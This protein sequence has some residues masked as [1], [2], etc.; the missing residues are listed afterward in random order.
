VLVEGGTPAP[1][2]GARRVLRRPAL[3]RALAGAGALVD[4]V[5]GLDWEALAGDQAPPGWL[6]ELEARRADGEFLRAP[7]MTRLARLAGVS[8]EHLSRSYARAYGTSLAA[9]LRAR[10]LRAGYDELTRS[11]RPLAEVAD[12]CGFADQSHLTRA[13]AEWIGLTPGALRRRGITPIQDEDP[14]GDV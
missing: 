1:R 10:R 6:R 11:S 4:L 7:G 5:E 3:V 14:D 2:G 12:R 9:A 8:R 13:L